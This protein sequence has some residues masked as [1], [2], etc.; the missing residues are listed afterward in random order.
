MPIPFSM[1]RADSKFEARNPKFETNPNVSNP[2]DFLM[3][4][5]F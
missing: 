5:D 3:V 4:L 2:K 1:E